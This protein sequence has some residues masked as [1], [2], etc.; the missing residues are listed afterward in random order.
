MPYTP[1]RIVTPGMPGVPSLLESIGEARRESFGEEGETVCSLKLWER[2][3]R[4]RKVCGLPPLHKSKRHAKDLADG[5]L[6]MREFW[7][8]GDDWAQ[9]QPGDDPLLTRYMAKI[10]YPMPRTVFA[11]ISYEGVATWREL[12][13]PK[14]DLDG[15]VTRDVY[16]P[17]FDTHDFY[18]NYQPKLF[19]TAKAITLKERIDDNEA[20]FTVAGGH[21]FY[22]GQV[23]DMSWRGYPSNTYSPAQGCKISATIIA[24]ASTTIRVKGG[25]GDL[26]PTVNNKCFIMTDPDDTFTVH[27]WR[28]DPRPTCDGVARVCDRMK[29][30][31]IG[32]Q[33]DKRQKLEKWYRTST[34]RNVYGYVNPIFEIRGITINEWEDNEYGQPTP[35]YN[36]IS[37]VYLGDF[38]APRGSSYREPAIKWKRYT[39]LSTGVGVSYLMRGFTVGSGTS[40]PEGLIMQ[41]FV[42]YNAT[43]F[44]AISGLTWPGIIYGTHNPEVFDLGGSIIVFIAEVPNWI[45]VEDTFLSASITDT[46][47]LLPVDSASTIPYSGYYKYRIG[48]EIIRVTD[49]THPELPPG[50]QHYIEVERGAEGTT[51][52]SHADGTPVEFIDATPYPKLEGL[53]TENWAN[54]T[55]NAP[56]GRDFMKRY[57]EGALQDLT[58]TTGENYTET[59]ENEFNAPVRTFTSNG[60]WLCPADVTRVTVNCWGGGGG[61]G[62]KGGG[63]GGAFAR[64]GIMTVTPGTSYAITVGTGG[65]GSPDGVGQDGGDSSF[66]TLVKAKGGKGGG[67]EAN[68]ITA[69]GGK[70]SDCIGDA[71]FSGGTGSKEG[72]GGSSAG[73]LYQGE[74]ANKRDGGIPPPY[75]GEGGTKS[76]GESPGGGGAATFDGGAGKVE[77]IEILNSM[78]LGGAFRSYMA[79]HDW[80]PY[81]YAQD[82]LD[83]K[84][85]PNAEPMGVVT[86]IYGIP[87]YYASND[88]SLGASGHGLRFGDGGGGEMVGYDHYLCPWWNIEFSTT[89]ADYIPLVT[90]V[91]TFVVTDECILYNPEFKFQHRTFLASDDALLI[92]SS[93]AGTRPLVA[94]LSMGWTNVLC[95][96]DITAAAYIISTDIAH[97]FKERNASVS[98]SG[99]GYT[100]F[101]FQHAD[102]AAYNGKIRL[103][104]RR[105]GTKTILK[106]GPDLFEHSVKEYNTWESMGW[107]GGL[108]LNSPSVLKQDILVTYEDITETAV[109]EVE[110]LAHVTGL[111]DASA[112][113]MN[114]GLPGLDVISE[115]VP[116]NYITSLA[117]LQPGQIFSNNISFKD[118]YLPYIQYDFQDSGF[119]HEANDGLPPGVK[120]DEQ[121]TE[122]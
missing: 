10:N 12:R 2:V 119:G 79:I 70:A 46:E 56:W 75:A 26:Y 32:R 74:N 8:K 121:V 17:W 115:G 25:R 88:I 1:N 68:E 20:I 111:I 30:T 84:S 43:R 7:V 53:V 87:Y 103:W 72:G 93:A 77:V 42:A 31:A 90:G 85:N 14:C 40:A 21:G 58:T 33:I 102:Y 107:Y 95:E 55:T 73:L 82:T 44:A 16:D 109:S 105:V 50:V 15:P 63:G 51:A 114:N 60:S 11:R 71:K 18:E 86:S 62:S 45:P 66:S 37:D 65:T 27:I 91:H 122:R 78:S 36:P 97:D 22:Q 99:S 54:G 47:T 100:D 112:Q 98:V 89:L 59:Q 96:Y 76:V 13:L 23:V 101:E 118:F 52:T 28:H 106:Y 108:T 38:P 67:S 80:I 39:N 49:T 48:N 24:V 116:E 92:L 9:A 104:R 113:A 6:A 34:G 3:N 120:Q 29:F 19:D 110:L 61:G 57:I 81:R 83:N 117:N 64:K 5:L 35:H 94:S 4:R 41:D 69:P